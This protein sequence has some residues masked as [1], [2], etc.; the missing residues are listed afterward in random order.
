[1]TTS[2]LIRAHFESAG[3]RECCLAPVPRRRRGTL[4]ALLQHHAAGFLGTVWVGGTADPRLAASSRPPTFG[5][6]SNHAKGRVKSALAR[7]DYMG[8]GLSLGS[9][10]GQVQCPLHPKQSPRSL[11]SKI[12]EPGPSNPWAFSK[13]PSWAHQDDGQDQIMLGGPEQQCCIR[14]QPSAS[15]QHQPA[16]GMAWPVAGTRPDFVCT[17]R[18][19][20]KSQRPCEGVDATTCSPHPAKQRGASSVLLAPSPRGE[21]H[22][23]LLL[24]GLAAL[25]PGRVLPA[26][27]TQRL[28]AQNE[29]VSGAGAAPRP[30]CAEEVSVPVR[31][32]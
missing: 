8:P 18:A 1:M 14:C 4:L 24:T 10:G 23:G 11:G 3:P 21:M 5:V 7:K 27:A 12:S 26:G 15:S 20:P 2:R 25:A 31:T 22:R 13:L 17:D 32:H 28:A 9:C 16:P 19:A 30:L 29:D 6:Y